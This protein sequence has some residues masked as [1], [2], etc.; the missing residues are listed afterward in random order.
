MTVILL[1]CFS[2]LLVRC[3]A[4]LILNEILCNRALMEFGS[5]SMWYMDWN[6]FLFIFNPLTWYLWTPNQ[7]EKHLK[8]RKQSK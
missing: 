8:S 7:L 5:P 4:G 2:I 3:F 6:V 1:S